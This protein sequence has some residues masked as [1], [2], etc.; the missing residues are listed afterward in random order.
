MDI[1]RVGAPFGGIRVGIQAVKSSST[2]RMLAPAT[3]AIYNAS[4]GMTLFHER[5]TLVF[6]TWRDG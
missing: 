4:G 6:S 5:E 2:V 3:R 1:R